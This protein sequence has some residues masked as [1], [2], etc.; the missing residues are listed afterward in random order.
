MSENDKHPSAMTDEERA[1][2]VASDPDAFDEE[3]AD[4]VTSGEPENDDVP[5]PTAADTPKEDAGAQEDDESK[6]V[7]QRAFNGVLAEL[8]ELRQSER[9]AKRELQELRE[10]FAAP[11]EPERDFDAERAA[12]RAKLEN[13]D[14]DDD[15]YQEAKD[16]LLVEQAELR[17][18]ARYE[19]QRQAQVRQQIEQQ[20]EQQA[21]SWN[22]KIGAWVE[23][24][25]EF[26][27]NP[28]RADAVAGLIQ[29]LGAD[30][31]VT[32]DDLLK[33]VESAAFDAFN[34]TAAATPA[35]NKHA[36]R[37]AADA[38]AA[39]AASAAPPAI[40]GGVGNRV[41]ASGI[42][43]TSLKPGTFSSLP[44]ADQERLLG[45]GALD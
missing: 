27:A 1:A 26:M 20:A 38:A 41:T 22:Q 9:E 16:A 2:L 14:I 3:R 10:R 13:G 35:P 29:K 42:D 17:A 34:W 18:V 28:I 39:A 5:P 31:N 8:R 12:L 33:Q 43:L 40:T 21:Q 36:G 45:E 11:A 24:N 44:K 32:D 30:P 15:Q 4:A 37:N 6:P 25:Q 7:N 23:Q 19:Q